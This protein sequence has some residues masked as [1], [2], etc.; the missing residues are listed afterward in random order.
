M[1]HVGKFHYMPILTEIRGHAYDPDRNSGEIED[2]SCHRDSD[3]KKYSQPEKDL[4]A[5]I[6]L[7]GANMA[8]PKEASPFQNPFNIAAFIKIAPDKVEEHQDD[9][10]RRTHHTG[11]SW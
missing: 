4:L 7:S 1:D 11:L 9:S 6:K 5:G 2:I 3:A 8:F 10:D